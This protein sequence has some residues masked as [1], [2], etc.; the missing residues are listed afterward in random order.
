M[1]WSLLG[2]VRLVL[3]EY[4]GSRSSGKQRVPAPRGGR[5]VTIFT[6]P[7][8]SKIRP[9]NPRNWMRHWRLRLLAITASA[10]I[11]G[12]DRSAAM[13]KSA[14]KRIR[15]NRIDPQVRLVLANGKKNLPFSNEEFDGICAE[16]ALFFLTTEK[17]LAE[18]HRLLKPGGMLGLTKGCGNPRWMQPSQSQSTIVQNL[19]LES[20][21]R[22]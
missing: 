22:P 9:S 7:P 16:S 21:R 3:H 19:A 6:F 4:S 15:R 2:P 11:V 5:G 8:R 12:L 10:C 18:C 1:V 20:L 17:I 13:L 14:Q